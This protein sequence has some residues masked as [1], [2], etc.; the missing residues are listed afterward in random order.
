MNP[1]EQE[2]KPSAELLSSTRQRLPERSK[3][4]APQNQHNRNNRSGFHTPHHVPRQYLPIARDDVTKS[5][6]CIRCPFPS[7]SRVIVFAHPDNT[8][9][10]VE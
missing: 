6:A 9:E 1:E 3:N 8:T 7:K 4:R 10:S 5:Y 2:M